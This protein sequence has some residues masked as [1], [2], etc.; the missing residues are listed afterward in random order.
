MT[1]IQQLYLG[2]GA[3][4][5]TYVD[6]VFSTYLWDGNS[7][8]RTIA[9][10]LNMS[11]EGGMVAI[12]SRSHTQ[13]W[14]IG[15][16][17]LGDNHCLA[18]NT[19]GGKDNQV[20]KFK[21]LKSTGFEI[22]N[23]HEVNSSSS[24]KTYSGFSYRKAPGFFD[25]VT[26]TGNPTSGGRQIAHSL[27]CVPGMIMIKCTSE[28]KDWIVYHRE[29]GNGKA[30]ELN[31]T[32]AEVT[33][34]T[35]WSDTDPTSTHFTLG[36]S[37]T[38]NGDSKD[39]IAYVFAGGESTAATAR[40]VD[41]DGNDWLTV[42]NS[43]DFNTG[44]GDFT[45]EAWIKPDASAT[46]YNAI[47]CHGDPYEIMWRLDGSAEKIQASFKA[48]EGGN[49]T[50]ELASTGTG[51]LRA[52]RGQ[53]SHVAIVRNGNNFDLYVNGNH[54]D[55]A[56]YSGSIAGAASDSGQVGN[57]IVTSNNSTYPFKGFIS[58]FRFVKGTAVYT[59]SFKPPT[60][61][62]TN[63]T[64]TKLLC[65]QNSTVT[66]YTVSP[67]T[68]TENGD[69]TASTDSPFDDPAAFTF[70]DNK[71]GIIKC[72]S[73]VGNG[74][75]SAAPEINLGWEPQWVMIKNTGESEGWVIFDSMRGII[76]SAN[77]KFVYSDHNILEQSMDMLELTP[78]GFKIKN[79]HNL[80]N[81]DGKT[82]I[83]TCVRRPDGYVGKPAEAGTDV[84]A[85]GTATGNSG[86]DIDSGFP[87]DF[88]LSRRTGMTEKWWTSARLMDGKIIATNNTDVEESSSYFPFDNNVGWTKDLNSGYKAW[89]WK[90]HT[91]FDVVTW[92]GDDVA[93]R[94]IRH[95]LNAVPQMIFVKNRS[96]TEPWAVYHYG[97][98]G[99]TNPWNYYG[100]L[101]TTSSF[102]T[103]P[104]MWDQTAPTSTY[105]RVIADNMTNGASSD[106]IAMLFASVSGISSVGYYNGS[107][108]DVTITTGFSPRFIII[109]RIDNTGS[110]QVFDTMRGL[111]SDNAADAI[112][113]LDSDGGSSTGTDY[114]ATSSTGFTVNTASADINANG[115]QHI[116]YA[117]A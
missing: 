95:N 26:Y 35:Y 79:S 97:A 46:S 94:D 80:I 25:V 10:G 44:S 19:T 57:Y 65:C 60:E 16:T 75:F 76:S 12:K 92:S 40:S 31:T 83:Y 43:S 62:L 100:K 101:D 51:S 89:M 71:E 45:I 87:V 98:N 23:D 84:F 73:Y 103:N 86:D 66:G 49:Y 17:G 7:S 85:M 68:I 14:V 22:G 29:L 102:N 107:S 52:S 55:N 77:E 1:P 81:T 67:G 91:G 115:G 11:G 13:D 38:V 104:N 106:Y 15:G 28:S 64:N 96:S 63:I 20:Q 90:R 33:S 88:G 111:N 72:G 70:G 48:T 116:Y 74:S 117:H 56:T 69:P 82:Y 41:M 112:M 59:S 93:G 37:I 24:S 113:A 8:T 27:G 18:F 50:V 4:K 36:T 105:F 110:W 99:G 3:G 9:T 47:W 58:N 6:D 30:L 61:P 108:S 32:D 109:K 114:I 2:V 39:Y 5:K 53:W 21:S 78:T 34:S 42:P 54:A